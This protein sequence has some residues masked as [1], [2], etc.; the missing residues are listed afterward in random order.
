MI[1]LKISWSKTLCSEWNGKKLCQLKEKKERFG[2]TTLSVAGIAGPVKG[3]ENV[4]PG[5]REGLLLV[6]G[7]I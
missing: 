6:L 5:E 2:G 7:K 1:V 3:N 4:R